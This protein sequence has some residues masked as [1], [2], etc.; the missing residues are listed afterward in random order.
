[1]NFGL[2]NRQTSSEAVPAIRIGPEADPVVKPPSTPRARQTAWS[3][4]PR[5][6]LTST[7][8]PRRTSCG[9]TA[10]ASWALASELVSPAKRSAI[11]GGQRP[12][13]DQQGDA[14][15]RGQLAELGA[16]CGDGACPGCEVGRAEPGAGGRWPRRGRPAADR[17]GR[18]DSEAPI[19]LLRVITDDDGGP[20]RD[21]LAL[22]QVP[23]Q[24]G[25]TLSGRP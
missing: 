21:G 11:G 13:G 18:D 3:P 7:Q 2:R 14:R 16:S 20:G 15:P 22:A 6:P 1:M 17:S 25:K 23:V 12:D 8:S 10:A 4:T 24:R 5:E 9:T 19:R